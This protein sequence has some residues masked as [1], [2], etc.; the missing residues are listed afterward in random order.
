MD[1]PL[2][3][4]IN[5]LDVRAVFTDQRRGQ[6]VFDHRLDCPSTL[7]AGISVPHAPTAVLQRDGNGNE[8]KMG[9][10]AVFGI[11]KYFWQGNGK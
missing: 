2:Q 11:G 9:V 5:F 4:I 10:I 3:E 1:M 8:F 7:A 6:I